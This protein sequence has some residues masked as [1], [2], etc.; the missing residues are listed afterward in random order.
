[1]LE[2]PYPP[3]MRTSF[4]N[5]TRIMHKKEIETLYRESDIPDESLRELIGNRTEED[6]SLLAEL[7]QK[8]CI[9]YYGDKV[10]IRGLIEISSICGNDCLY[11]GLRR[12]NKNALRYRPTK[13]EIL[14]CCEKGYK[15]GFRTFV[16]Q[17]GEDA[18]FTDGILCEIE[19]EGKE[20]SG[21]KCFLSKSLTVSVA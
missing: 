10:F 12:S 16:M 18:Y 9:E 20:T 5:G 17:G 3:P 19:K 4:K 13:E 8:R 1:M 7:A 15:L 6:R 14:L 2:N 21:Y 11:C